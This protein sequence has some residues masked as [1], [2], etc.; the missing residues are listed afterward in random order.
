MFNV[1]DFKN[2]KK[3]LIRIIQLYYIESANKFENRIF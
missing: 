1:D 2:K 3:Y